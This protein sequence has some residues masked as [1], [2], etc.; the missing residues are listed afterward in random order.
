M[1]HASALIQR[2]NNG[3]QLE[4]GA[5]VWVISSQS[6]TTYSVG[7]EKEFVKKHLFCDPDP[8]SDMNAKAT[9]LVGRVNL[10]GNLTGNN[11]E[12]L[13]TTLDAATLRFLKL[14]KLVLARVSQGQCS[15]CHQKITQHAKICGNCG[16]LH[17]KPW[18]GGG[19]CGVDDGSG[20][21][22]CAD[23]AAG[24]GG[25]VANGVLQACTGYVSNDYD[26]HRTS[27]GKANPF[28]GSGGACTGT[29]TVVLMDE[30]DVQAFKD[31]VVNAIQNENTAGWPPGQWKAGEGVPLE[32]GANT[33]ATIKSDDS[34][35]TFN[36]RAKAKGVK[37]HIKKGLDEV[38]RI[39]HFHDTIA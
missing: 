33:V 37:V 32:F 23:W 2:N 18:A 3:S 20:A 22:A 38:Y 30:I 8:P 36:Q 14:K 27:K 28:G 7:F 16:H 4:S 6:G 35:L 34:L 13:P 19:A 39:Y 21:C 5:Q 24:A 15:V 31:V 11:V 26:L 1:P 12:T 9:H 29:N 17:K 10:Y 25:I